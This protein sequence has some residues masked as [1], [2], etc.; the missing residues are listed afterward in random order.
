M[1]TSYILSSS[2]GML[3]SGSRVEADQIEI[4]VSLRKSLACE[5]SVNYLFFDFYFL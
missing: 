3:E 4:H 1:K 2:L 5:R